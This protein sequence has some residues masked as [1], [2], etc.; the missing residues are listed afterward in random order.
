MDEVA[1]DMPDFLR[2]FLNTPEKIALKKRAFA[3]CFDS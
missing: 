1:E 2:E 3:Q